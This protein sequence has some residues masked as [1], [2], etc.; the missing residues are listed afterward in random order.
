MSDFS[1]Y[2]G[3]CPICESAVEFERRG[4]WLRD[5]LICL[6]CGSIPRWRALLRVLHDFF[7]SWRSLRLHESSPGGAASEKLRRDCVAYVGS[8]FYPDVARG[9]SRDG[10]RSEDL[11]RQTF[12]DAS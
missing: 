6:G 10:Y 8:H 12:A 3:A 11:E 5:Q 4:D 7:P 1:R 2:A 9:E